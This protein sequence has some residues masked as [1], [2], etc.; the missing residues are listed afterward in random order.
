MGF[1]SLCKEIMGRIRRKHKKTQRLKIAGRTTVGPAS[2]VN[3]RSGGITYS[4]SSG[5]TAATKQAAPK[6]KKNFFPV[7]FFTEGL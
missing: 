6:Y 4:D 5:H 7:R 2:W 3:S 1:N